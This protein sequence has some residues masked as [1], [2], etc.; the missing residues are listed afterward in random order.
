ME[1]SQESISSVYNF[2]ID[3][4]NN[5][6]DKKDDI[7]SDVIKKADKLDKLHVEIKEKLVLTGFKLLSSK[8]ATPYTC[9]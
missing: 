6:P 4:L 9:P 7:S 2:P 1:K 8:G 3:E 5:E